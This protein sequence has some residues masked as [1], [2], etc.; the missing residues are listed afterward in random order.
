VEAAAL[1]TATG[2]S[3][4]SVTDST[5][6]VVSGGSIPLNVNDAT[7]VS[8]TTTNTSYLYGDLLFGGTAPVE[9][10]TTTS[11][12]ATV[13]YLVS[14]QTGVQGVFSS[15]GVLQELALYS[16]YGI[17]TIMSGTRVTPFGYQGSYT[18]STGLIYL[19]DRY[20][21]PSTDQFLSIDPDV[22]QTDQ[23]Y[24]YTGDDPLN[25]CDPLGDL[26]TTLGG[27]AVKATPEKAAPAKTAPAQTSPPKTPV[28]TSPSKVWLAPVASLPASSCG[29]LG[30]TLDNSITSV[31]N[32]LGAVQAGSDIATAA[33]FVDEPEDTV[34][35]AIPLLTSEATGGAITGL[36]C[37]KAGLDLNTLTADIGNVADCA[38]N[39]E[40]TFLL[41]GVITSQSIQ[42]FAS[43]GTDLYKK[44]ASWF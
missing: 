6:D 20:Y 21:D 29:L 2:S 9:Q 16:L 42:A 26:V 25:S 13:R 17:Q 22:A 12:G 24:I 40:N 41:K 43:V 18:D 11:S 27:G 32:T 30:C 14:N 3:S 8:G 37:A 38:F 1:L 15:S 36:T 35:S 31:A 23:P 28:K 5:W 33:S 44:V 34:A 19:I 10:I 39:F 7:T 4:S